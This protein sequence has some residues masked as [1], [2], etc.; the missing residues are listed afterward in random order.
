MV[1]GWDVLRTTTTFTNNGSA[2]LLSYFDTFDPD[3]T[4][5]FTYNNVFN[6][7]TGAGTAKVGRASDNFSSGPTVVM[8]SLDPSVTVASGNPFSITSGSRLNSFFSSPYDGNGAS[9]DR[10]THVGIRLSLGAGESD[11]FTFDQAYGSSP[12]NAQAQFIGA[13][14]TPAPIP[15]PIPVPGAFVLGAIGLGTVGWVK[16]RR[17]G[18]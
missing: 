3:Q 6:L 8:G 16:R 17:K 12:A 9:A 10:G 15:A 13:N 7:A 18:A 11:S 14:P 4:D 1:P 5:Y 2:I